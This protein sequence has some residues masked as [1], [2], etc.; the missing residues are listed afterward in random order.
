MS[1]RPQP[2]QT[3]DV[4]LPDSV[5]ALSERLAEHIHDIWAQRRLA[6]GWRFGPQRSDE[7]RRHPDLVPYAALAE[8]EKDYD[9]STVFET[10]KAIIALEY[11]IV[12]PDK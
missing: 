5:H 1:Y 2:I 4:V 10:L 8:S 6:E 11:R 7:N 12:P 9:R 3:D